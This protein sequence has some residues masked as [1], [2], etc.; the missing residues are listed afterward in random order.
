MIIDSIAWST[1]N[2]VST[3]VNANMQGFGEINNDTVLSAA[4]C[5]LESSRTI[6]TTGG[7][8]NVPY[9]CGCVSKYDLGTFPTDI[10]S[11][12]QRAFF[13]YCEQAILEDPSFQTCVLNYPEIGEY[14]GKNTTGF[15][16]SAKFCALQS[17]I[18]SGVNNGCMCGKYVW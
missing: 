11:C 13:Y 7:Y 10:F 3:C 1:V 2:N 17:N 14:F 4:L 5:Q 12:G 18:T 15:E 9:E 6:M 16:I 8:A